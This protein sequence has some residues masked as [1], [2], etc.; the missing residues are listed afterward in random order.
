MKLA[1]SNIAWTPPERAQAY[2]LLEE[3]G[4]GGLEIAAGLAF[5]QADDPFAPSAADLTKFRAT[6]A[7]HGLRLVSMQS[8]LFGVV[9][10][11]LFG[12]PAQRQAF[13]AGIVRAIA[14]AERLGIPNLVMGSPGARS[15]PEGAD[16]DAAVQGA[17]AVFSRLG[18]ACQ[19]AGTRL[20]LEPNPAAYGTNFLN[21]IEET[22]AF[23]D[24]VNHPAVT[25]NFDLGA[26]HMNGEAD[27]AGDL[28]RQAAHRV[29]HLH[30]SEP[31]LAPAP[32]DAGRL[33]AILGD[34]RAG[35]YDGW[36]SIEMRSQ[37]DQNLGRVRA[38][39]IAAARAVG[40]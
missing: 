19:A 35:G 18:D 9:D 5:P 3:L 14:L 34:I 36:A 16:R 33:A 17:L 21:T 11:Q 27:R 7:A 23:A 28:Y 31:Q 10:A 29:S 26:L 20:A 32:A 38:S 24:A 40:P 13:E 30:V 39:V 6:L 22:V 1:I 8:L 37:G 2:A 4:V 15:I 25:V 12:A